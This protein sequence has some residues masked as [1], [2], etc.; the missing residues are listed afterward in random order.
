MKV[1]SKQKVST[2]G[3]TR[4]QFDSPSEGRLYVPRSKTGLGMYTFVVQD[5]KRKYS[6]TKHCSEQEAD[7]FVQKFS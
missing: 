3:R 1:I 6:M 4:N 5:G 2:H 7:A